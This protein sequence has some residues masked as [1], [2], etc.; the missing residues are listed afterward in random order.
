[1]A[2]KDMKKNR[3]TNMA[4]LTEELTKVNSNKPGPDDRFWK[5]EVDKAGNGYAVIRFLPAVEG[6]D[7]PYVRIFE[8]AF[9]GPGGWY[10]EKSLSTL[11]EADPCGE[12]NGKLWATGT[13]ENQEIVRKQKRK[14]SFVANILVVSDKAHPECEGKV[15]MYKFG[16]KIFDKITAAMTP[17]FEDEQPINPFDMWEGANFKLKIRQV[18]GYRN[19][20]K[21][22]FDS[23]SAI[24]E[25]D[26]ELEAIYNSEYK[27]QP[28]I[29]RSEFKTYEQL[30]ERLY[31]V[32][33]LNAAPAQSAMPSVDAADPSASRSAPPA[34][35]ASTDVPFAA[36]DDGGD[37]DLDFFKRLG[38]EQ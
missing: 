8:H 33:G 34:R 24:S 36:D 32:L 16:K 23:P 27:L 37:D 26:D 7:V 21:S 22:E 6:E 35:A 20:D 9:Q 31:R 19:F 28:L 10:I 25:D 15:F 4:K 13:K 5:P 38:I 18:E 14:L 12:Y 17:E 2:F 1:M 30:Q 3:A 29:A 11:G